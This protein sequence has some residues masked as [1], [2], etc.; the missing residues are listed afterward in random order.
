MMLSFLALSEDRTFMV[1]KLKTGESL[2]VSEIIEKTP[3]GVSVMLEDGKIKYFS[4]KDMD[5]ES[6]ERFG[7]DV[8]ALEWYNKKIKADKKVSKQISDTKKEEEEKKVLEQKIKDTKYYVTGNVVRKTKSGLMVDCGR[9]TEP[10]R[11]GYR[12]VSN[13]PM[14]RGSVSAYQAIVNS[15]GYTTEKSDIKIIYGMIILKSYPYENSVKRG[16]EIRI[17][18]FKLD[19]TEKHFMEDKQFEQLT[20]LTCD[21]PRHL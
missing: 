13:R 18:A 6:A 15:G 21:T 4:F 8:N 1:L 16:D 17:N 12:V 7:Y 14:T 11:S 10:A 20:C 19:A 5:K 9:Y 3:P 2:S